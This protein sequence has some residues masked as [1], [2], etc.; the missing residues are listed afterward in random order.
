MSA[1]DAPMQPSGSLASRPDAADGWT[2]EGIVISQIRS[3]SLAL[4]LVRSGRIAQLRAAVADK[5]GIE[6]PQDLRV[7]STERLTLMSCGPGAY[8]AA[9][10]PGASC[11]SVVDMRQRF[12][13]LAEV[14]DCS[15]NFTVLGL[16]GPRA[17][18]LVARICAIDL[19]ARELPAQLAIVTL[20]FQVRTYVWRLAQT[21]PYT[22]AVP[23]SMAVGFWDALLQTAQAPAN[24]A[25]SPTFID[26]FERSP[27]IIAPSGIAETSSRPRSLGSE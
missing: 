8:L 2:G 14:V 21:G 11:A 7:S 23:R 1:A 18:E 3:P 19:N 5:L 25:V 16:G 4:I 26:E 13:E 27:G 15:D 20:I 6:L 24:D 12:G 9:S 17:Q 22:M 10:T